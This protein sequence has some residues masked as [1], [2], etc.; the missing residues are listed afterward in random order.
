[1]ERTRCPW[2]GT[3][4]LYVKYH[5]EEWGV[6]VHSDR[7]HFEFLILEGAQAGLSWAT[8]L[9]RREGYRKAFS[10][11][12]PGLVAD[13]DNEKIEELLKNSGIIRNKRKILSAINN[14]RAFLEVQKEFGS[15]D[16]Y[17]W[18]FVGGN[19]IVNQWKSL[20]EV[21]AYTELSI[22]LSKDLKKRGF[23]FVG[24]TI[25]YAHMQAVGLVNDHLVSCFRHKEVQQFY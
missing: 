18:S 14:A 12:D 4:P 10:G 1:M 24:P 21:P 15:F 8:I 17:I 19:P 22:A 20:E 25:T 7:I 3:D 6:P 2:A 5:D 11:F 13:Y 23:S 9:K 16:S